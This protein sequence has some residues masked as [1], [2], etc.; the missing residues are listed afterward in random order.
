MRRLW[1][2]MVA[3]LACGCG[4]K[5]DPLK[6]GTAES[7]LSTRSGGAVAANSGDAV[8]P[9]P[10]VVYLDVYRLQ[11]PAGAVSR[12]DEFWKRVDEQ[13]VDVATYDVLSRNGLRVGVGRDADWH[14][15]KGLI[16]QSG[17]KCTR[18]RVNAAKEG[19][20]E[21]P[22]KEGMQFQ[23]L[24]W[25]DDRGQ[26]AGHS[27]EKCDDLLGIS[28]QA[29]PR[30]PG[31]VVVKV[32]PIVRGLR[33]YFKV[34]LMGEEQEIDLVQPEHLYDLRLEALIPFQDFLIIAPSSKASWPTSLGGSFLV[35]KGKAEPLEDV[36]LIVPRP[37]QVDDE[38]TRGTAK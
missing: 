26:L 16:S 23:N 4:A 19:Y 32:C 5:A 18:G 25:F 35:S 15:F 20:V 37:F 24:F 30:R 29:A 10:I 36:L 34:S 3:A 8:R 27:Y 31:E 28:F 14:Y 2:V 33:R 1:L 12:N 13:R 22:M 38:T 6:N 11:V 7:E 9:V 17:G 21:L